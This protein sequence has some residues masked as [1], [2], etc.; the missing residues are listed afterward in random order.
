MVRHIVHSVYRLW[1]CGIL[2]LVSGCGSN[3]Y[4]MQPASDDVEVVVTGATVQDTVTEEV[5]QPVAFDQC[6]SGSPFKANIKFS[7]SSGQEQQ[8]KVV[9]TLGAGAEVGLS[10][11]AKAKVQGTLER[12]LVSIESTSAGREESV[13]IEVPAHTRQQY[14]ITWRVTKRTGQMKYTTGGTAGVADYSYRFG[15]QLV[16]A[17]GQD[18]PCPGQKATEPAT[19]NTP[20]DTPT[21]TDTP[22]MSTV[23]PSAPTPIPSPIPPSPTPTADPRLF[24]DDFSNLPKAEWGMEG[25]GWAVVKSQFVADSASVAGYIGNQTWSDYAVLLTG[26]YIPLSSTGFSNRYLEVP[27]RMADRQQLHR[28]EGLH[29]VGG[30]QQLGVQLGQ[31]CQWH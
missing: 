14:T 26:L 16:S 15:V 3:R 7:Q 11:V 17:A 25:T 13:E 18:L 23:A 30:F 28:P 12:H 20:A 5:V 22:A 2:I 8:D 19:S 27:V 29:R 9:V 31:G 1:I 6:Q 24:W 10:E 4:A 21:P